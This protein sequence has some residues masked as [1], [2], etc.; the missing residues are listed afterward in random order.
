MN[1]ARIFDKIDFGVL[2]D[3]LV[4]ED[5]RDIN[6]LNHNEIWVTSNHHGHYRLMD[7]SIPETEINRIANQVANKMEKEFNPGSPCLE[8]DIHDEELDLRVSAIHE[9]R[10]LCVKYPGP[11]FSVRTIWWKA[12][13]SPDRHCSF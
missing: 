2:S 11:V 13:L 3:L 9:E 7:R 6:C 12:V 1:D 8:G 5:I 4:Q 10:W